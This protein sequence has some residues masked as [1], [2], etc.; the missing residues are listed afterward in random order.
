[1]YNY[2]VESRL[3]FENVKRLRLRYMGAIIVKMFPTFIVP[4]L[5]QLVYYMLY[6]DNCNAY[7]K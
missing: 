6:K 7:R 1:M 5:S 3:P 4:I 2:N